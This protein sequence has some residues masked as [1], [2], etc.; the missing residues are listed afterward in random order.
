LSP[1]LWFHLQAAPRVDPL[2]VGLHSGDY[3]NS[4]V[5]QTADLSLSEHQVS[6]TS[7]AIPLR[8]IRSGVRANR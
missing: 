7:G 4:S 3:G 8:L 2:E 6:M 1:G 5:V